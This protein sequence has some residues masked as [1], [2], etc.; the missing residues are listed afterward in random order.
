[1]NPL[2]SV[3]K[4]S[5]PIISSWLL[6]CSYTTYPIFSFFSLSLWFFPSP[7]FL[8]FTS[9]TPTK[10]STRFRVYKCKTWGPPFL[11]LSHT[12]KDN[13]HRSHSE[14]RRDTELERNQTHNHFVSFFV[15]SKKRP[16]T[17]RTGPSHALPDLLSGQRD[18]QGALVFLVPVA[19]VT[20]CEL[21]SRTQLRSL[22]ALFYVPLLFGG[23][24]SNTT[25]IHKPLRKVYWK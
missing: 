24:Q 17:V 21:S 15:A 6:H 8:S 18:M 3:A 16:K 14:N 1:M 20:G 7:F 22:S 11:A 9:V 12:W 19:R 13:L 5:T 10:I 2:T 23:K 25:S 4:R